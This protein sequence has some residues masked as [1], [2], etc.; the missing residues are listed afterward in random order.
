MISHGMTLFPYFK[1]KIRVFL[2]LFTGTKESGTGIE[3]F[4]QDEYFFG[5][6][7]CG[8]IVEGEINLFARP[9]NPPGYTRE[10]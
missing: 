6:T 7:R 4:K 8:S 9:G 2:Y 5:D 1:K 3:F 10:Q